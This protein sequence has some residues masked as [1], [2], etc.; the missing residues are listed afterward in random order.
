[1]LL[2]ANVYSPSVLFD[3]S[4]DREVIPQ[5]LFWIAAFIA[6]LIANAP[7]KRISP[8]IAGVLQ[9]IPEKLTRG[10]LPQ[11]QDIV[12]ISNQIVSLIVVPIK[13]LFFFLAFL[14]IAYPIVRAVFKSAPFWHKLGLKRTAL[15][16]LF[17]FLLLSLITFP[18]ANP[19][20]PHQGQYGLSGMGI[21][22]GRMSMAPFAEDDGALYSRLL[23]PAIANFIQMDG[24]VRYYLFSLV[25]TYLLVFLTLVFLESK[26]FLNATNGGDQGQTLRPKARW[27]VYLS[28]MTSA[29]ILVSFQQP[30]KVEHLVFILILLMVCIPM[31]SQARLGSITLS[32]LSHDGSAIA[33]LPVILFCFPKEEKL[34]ALL[35]MALF[36]GLMLASYG[37]NFSEGLQGHGS[38][39]NEG[40]V[41]TIVIQYPA[42][43]LAGLFF[44]YKLFWL[45]FL[46]VLWM[47]WLQKHKVTM[48][49]LTAITLFPI[50]LCL[51]AWDTT[52]VN[53]VGFLGVLI[54]LVILMKNFQELPRLHYQLLLLAI[55]INLFIPTYNVV[56]WPPVQGGPPI[57]LNSLS[58]YSYPGLYMLVNSIA[59]RFLT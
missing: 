33:L 20:G 19:H 11:N 47:L 7:P 38:M 18:Y 39:V 49:A 51:I 36:Y 23:K 34:N 29:F 8:L 43:F 9:L 17:L 53:G 4:E 45:V 42:Y 58:D 14:V 54:G 35:I 37:F 48:A 41:W 50:G 27:V 10:L 30:G 59:H 57:W 32:T 15:S 6:F 28:I 26:I 12:Q 5:K 31:T 21:D 52:R 3:I 2:P 16:A 13:K 22:Y 1:M 40:S 55:Y 24:Y 56:L 46:Y 25:C 44:S